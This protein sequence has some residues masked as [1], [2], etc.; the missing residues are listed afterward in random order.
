MTTNQQT[1][2]APQ[3]PAEQYLSPEQHKIVSAQLIDRI[4]TDVFFS[5]LSEFNI[6]PRNQEEAEQLLNIGLSIDKLGQ[7]PAIKQAE[8]KQKSPS[9]LG[10]ANDRLN[11]KLAEF[12]MVAPPPEGDEDA[13]NK[14]AA[15]YTAEPLVQ[16]AVLSVYS[17]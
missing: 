6:V 8:A 11:E 14:L 12:G 3:E 16:E 5:K 1:P 13:I 17:Q 4:T 15:I 9:F 10:F 2:A 7:H